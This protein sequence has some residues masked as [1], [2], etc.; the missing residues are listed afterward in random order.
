MQSSWK[1]AFYEVVIV[2]IVQANTESMLII[3]S[4]QECASYLTKYLYIRWYISAVR[5]SWQWIQMSEFEL[6]DN[7]WNKVSRP[8]WTTVETS[9][10]SYPTNEWPNNIIDW[11]TSTKHYCQ[12]QFIPLT[13]TINLWSKLDFKNIKQYKRYTANDS[14]QRDPITWTLAVSNDKVNWKTVSTVTNASITS[15]RNTLAWTWNITL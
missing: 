4:N 6:Y 5:T 1:L 3:E 2:E 15:N 9:A 11:T 10:T 8:S 7:S 14:Y 13:L 12:N